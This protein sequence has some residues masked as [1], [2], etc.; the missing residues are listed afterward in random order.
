MCLT[1]IESVSKDSSG[2]KTIVATIIFIEVV[3]IISVLQIKEL[4]IRLGKGSKVISQAGIQTQFYLTPKSALL[5]TTGLLPFY[6]LTFAFNSV[7]FFVVCTF[8]FYCKL[9]K[10]ILLSRSY[11]THICIYKYL[12]KFYFICI[13]IE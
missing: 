6:Y 3:S 7:Y 8:V 10:I 1:A 9:L 5:I 11:I 2:I 4:G 13:L 12:P